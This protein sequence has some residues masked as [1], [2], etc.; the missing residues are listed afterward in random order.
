M[1][2]IQSFLGKI[3]DVISKATN[4]RNL[5]PLEC[6]FK[7]QLFCKCINSKRSGA[8]LLSCLS[9]KGILSKLGTGEANE[10]LYCL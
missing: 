5:N 6:N 8:G 3:E 9:E 4:N 7:E 2:K 10:A 1:V